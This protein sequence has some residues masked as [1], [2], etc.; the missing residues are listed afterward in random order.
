MNAANQVRP[1]L[2]GADSTF[3]QPEAVVSKPFC[4]IS[5][6]APSTACTTA[7]LVR[8]DLFNSKVMLPTEA[9]DSII[10]ASYVSVKG[11]RY[12]ALPST[13]AEFIVSGGTGVNQE[14]IDRMLG[15]WGGDASKLFP[16]MSVFASS[17]V[18][19]AAFSADD[20]APE[21]V[22]AS[23]NGST[24][25]WP[26]SPSND[27]IGY[28]VY[29]N[30]ERIATIIDGSSNS[31]A[32]GPGDYYVRAV[33]ITGLLSGGSNIVIVDNP[34]QP[35]TETPDDENTPPTSPGNE[36]NGD[37]NGDGNNGNENNGENNGNNGN[38]SNGNN[39]GGNKPPSD[40]DE[41]GDD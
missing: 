20:A 27:V 41:E 12:M 1:D 40:G 11:S 35:T 29:R 34:D 30:N 21:G 2:I 3:K 8:S 22:S 19:G 6:L 32:V 13:P 38:N 28:Y 26:D 25:V 39:G 14:F 7:G 24:L 4:G 10:N 23:L 16:S 31:I 9:D 18:S 36:G 17:V 15:P 37:E 5:G 33:D